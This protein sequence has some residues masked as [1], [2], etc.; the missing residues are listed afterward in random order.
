MKPVAITAI[1]MLLNIAGAYMAVVGVLQV[2]RLGT[3]AV[4]LLMI[5]GAWLWLGHAIV[6]RLTRRYSSSALESHGNAAT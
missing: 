6:V 1:W 5:F 4:G 2:G 3:A